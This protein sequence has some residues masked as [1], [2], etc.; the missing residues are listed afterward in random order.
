MGGEERGIPLKHGGPKNEKRT[1]SYKIIAHA[2]GSFAIPWRKDSD[3]GLHLHDL[4]R[5]GGEPELRG[6]CAGRRF[7]AGP[8]LGTRCR[9]HGSEFYSRLKLDCDD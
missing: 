4:C 7:S 6:S 3:H 5:F 9:F 1:N 2:S 8:N